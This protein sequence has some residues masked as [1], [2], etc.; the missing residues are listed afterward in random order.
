MKICTKCKVEKDILEFHKNKSICKECRKDLAKD[1]Y[2]KNKEKINN[3]SK[4][5]KLTNREIIK[6]SNK[7]YYIKNK[8]QT[9]KRVKIH[10]KNNREK[11]KIYQKEYRKI[12]KEKINKQIII[13][14]KKRKKIDINFRILGNLRTRIYIALKNK[15][16]SLNTMFLTGCEID[17][18]MFHIQNQF[19]KDMN[20]D[21][22]GEWHIDHIK[23]CAK[24]D[25][26]D[27]K[28][29]QKCFNYTNLQ[30]L[31]AEDNL[32]KSDKILKVMN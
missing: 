2:L 9:K 17:Y 3:N 15:H 26:S 13:Y 6:K 18:L 19:T 1:Y 14:N 7:K 27:P 30:P 29:Q 20:W 8:E 31:W 4:E 25:L 16:K 5:W 21:N 11:Y 10:R 22:Y 12:N 23:P 24:F 28:E 32:R